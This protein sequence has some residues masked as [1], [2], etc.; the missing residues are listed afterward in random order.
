MFIVRIG[1]TFS[2]SRVLSFYPLNK[3]KGR[4]YIVVCGCGNFMVKYNPELKRGGT[5]AM[6]YSCKR[7]SMKENPHLK[8]NQTH[9]ETGSYLHRTWENMRRRCRGV[10]NS[11]N[12][13]DKGVTVCQEWDTNYEAFAAYVRANL[14]E[15]PDGHS[16]DRIDNDGDYEPGNIRWATDSEQM[17]NRTTG[18]KWRNRK[19]VKPAVDYPAWESL[20]GD[21]PSVMHFRQLAAHLG[22]GEDKLRGILGHLGKKC[23]RK[24]YTLSERDPLI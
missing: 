1:D 15:R 19:K 2:G 21:L 17:L 4:A 24:P 6:C 11:Q 7:A 14:G 22:V 3:S 23:I 13:K 9:G 8:V 20:I 18:W 10:W 5:S 16:L 12:W